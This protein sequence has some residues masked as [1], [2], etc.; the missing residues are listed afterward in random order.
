MTFFI[1]DP[2]AG[3]KFK[4]IRIAP[5]E[6]ST[7]YHVYST[8]PPHVNKATTFAEGWGDTRFAP[9]TGDDGSPV[10]TY[11]AASSVECA[12]LESV[13]HDI[14]LYPPGQ[15]NLDLLQHHRIAEIAFADALD[16]VSFHTPH[17]PALQLTRAQLIDSLPAHYPKTRAWAQAAYQQCANAQA[18]AYGSR[19]Y[20]AH[21]CIMLFGQ[22]IA[23]PPFKVV[24]DRPLA[25]APG[26][27]Q[28]LR[29]VE[30]LGIGIS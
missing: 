22:R 15:L 20:D 26:R 25:I 17:L 2:S 30:E 7:W 5:T 23:P 16:C 9:L 18:I 6:V 10:H 24:G 14:P 29:L 21:R 8:K 1:P 12:I 11:Y 19:R 13:L 27:E 28:V 4:T 3:A